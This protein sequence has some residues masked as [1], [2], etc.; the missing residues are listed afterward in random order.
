METI[1]FQIS[2]KRKDSEVRFTIGKNNDYYF[3]SYQ[4]FIKLKAKNE[5][6]TL[7]YVETK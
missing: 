1:Y 6:K 7:L 3:S 5:N 2:F 4:D